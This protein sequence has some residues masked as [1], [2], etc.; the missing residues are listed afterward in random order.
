MA[1]AGDGERGV[2]R[3]GACATDECGG[4]SEEVGQGGQAAAKEFTEAGES[5]AEGAEESG[6]GAKEAVAAGA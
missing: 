6:E 5:A 4:V 3:S 1:G 2:V